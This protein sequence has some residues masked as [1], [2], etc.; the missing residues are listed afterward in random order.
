MDRLER[1]I[2]Q[3]IANRAGVEVYNDGIPKWAIRVIGWLAGGFMALTVSGI[4][5]GIVMYG[6]VESLTASVAYLTRLV[7][8]HYRGSDGKP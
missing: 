2:A 1:L 4:V 5:G 8:P 3:A 6:K 7:E